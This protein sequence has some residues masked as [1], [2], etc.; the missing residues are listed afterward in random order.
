MLFRRLRVAGTVQRWI[1]HGARPR[2]PFRILRVGFGLARWLLG[3]F[4]LEVLVS[5]R[6]EGRI[7]EGEGARG[8][9]FPVGLLFLFRRWLLNTGV[10]RPCRYRESKHKGHEPCEYH[11]HFHR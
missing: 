8:G 2:R 9:R 10:L 3:L 6:L 7:F 4:N 11:A 5:R 1:L